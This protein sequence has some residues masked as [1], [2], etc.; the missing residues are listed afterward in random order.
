MI[1]ASAFVL[2]QMSL[3]YDKADCFFFTVFFFGCFVK[4]V[5]DKKRHFVSATQKS[6]KADTVVQKVLF[7]W[8]ADRLVTLQ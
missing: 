8:D 7:R 2:P 1:L 3:V 4:V 5:N 6:S